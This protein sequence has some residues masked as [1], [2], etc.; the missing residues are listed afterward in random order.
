MTIKPFD[1]QTVLNHSNAK[2]VLYSYPHCNLKKT[3]FQTRRF[4]LIFQKISKSEKLYKFRLAIFGG[5]V[6]QTSL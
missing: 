5:K 4:L 1:Y 6:S 3:G 2:L